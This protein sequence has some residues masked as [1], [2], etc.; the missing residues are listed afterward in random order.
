MLDEGDYMIHYENGDYY[1]GGLYGGLRTGQGF[2]LE[3]G[4]TYNG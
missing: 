3:Q 4:V 1:K 2:A